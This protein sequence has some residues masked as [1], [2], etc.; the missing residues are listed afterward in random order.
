MKKKRYTKTRIALALKQLESRTPVSEIVRNMKNS[1]AMN[2]RWKQKYDGLGVGDVRRLQQL[3][4]ESRK[5]KQLVADLS[6]DKMMLQDELMGKQWRLL[7]G[8]TW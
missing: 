5:L 7:P 3:D 8:V 6:L 1:E 4:E 2:Y